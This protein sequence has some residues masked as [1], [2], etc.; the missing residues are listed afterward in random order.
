MVR[1]PEGQMFG[2][3][4]VGLQ[5]ISAAGLTVISMGPQRFGMSFCS[6]K[7]CYQGALMQRAR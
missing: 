6:A 3:Y 7:L 4:N 1:C 2:C 5:I